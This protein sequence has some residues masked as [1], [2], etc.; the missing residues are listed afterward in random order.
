MENEEATK[1]FKEGHIYP[2][3]VT[4]NKSQRARGQTHNMKTVKGATRTT[5]SNAVGASAGVARG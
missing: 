1:G 3:R 2:Q 5:A 4:E